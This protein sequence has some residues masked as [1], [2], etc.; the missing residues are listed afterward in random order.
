MTAWTREVTRRLGGGTPALP[1]DGDWPA[2]AEVSEAAWKA[3]K[4]H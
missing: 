3:H 4:P 2:V 1:E